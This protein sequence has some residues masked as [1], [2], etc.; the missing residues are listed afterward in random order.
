M[1]IRY[2]VI[3]QNELFSWRDSGRSQSLKINQYLLFS[4]VICWGIAMKIAVDCSFCQE[5]G[6]IWLRWQMWDGKLIRK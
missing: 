1:K 2:E 5:L 4:L 6:C 3:F